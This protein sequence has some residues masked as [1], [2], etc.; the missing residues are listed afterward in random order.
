MNI[1]VFSYNKTK[2]SV[3]ME[4][5]GARDLVG[6]AWSPSSRV[7]QFHQIRKHR[8]IRKQEAR[9]NSS[10]FQYAKLNSTYSNTVTRKLNHRCHSHLTQFQS[11]NLIHTKTWTHRSVQSLQTHIFYHEFVIN[12]CY[13]SV[14]S[15]AFYIS[16]LLV[17]KTLQLH[18]WNYEIRWICSIEMEI[19]EENSHKVKMWK[20]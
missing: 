20:T 1:S 18:N 10:S 17:T 15:N 12:F 2:K 5:Q 13:V 14:Q 4:F 7:F 16:S 8:K 19:D 11:L 3:W 6:I 9:R